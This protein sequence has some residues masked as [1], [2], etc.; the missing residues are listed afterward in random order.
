ME[1][2]IY[3]YLPEGLQFDSL[4][5][6]QKLRLKNFFHKCLM[7][8]FS[9]GEIREQMNSYLKRTMSLYVEPLEYY[10]PKNV[11]KSK[12]TPYK[13]EEI[14]KI[15]SKIKQGSIKYKL[16]RKRIREILYERR[17]R[18]EVETLTFILTRHAY[19]RL[20]ER[21]GEELEKIVN[22]DGSVTFTGILVRRGHETHL[23][24]PAYGTFVLVRD[25]KDWVA[26][27]YLYPI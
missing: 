19:Q 18:D 10:L 26:K 20:K 7:K 3:Q 24:V 8:K 5:G 6:K 22:K 21:K 13:M 15:Y 14:E 16:A 25:G 23:E 9:E 1:N 2:D 11:D 12:I 27:T 17:R 4:P